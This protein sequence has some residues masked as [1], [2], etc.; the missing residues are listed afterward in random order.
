MLQNAKKFKAKIYFMCGDNEGDADVITDLNN[1]EYLVNT[2]RCE[3]KMLN[4]KVIVKGGQ[5]NEKLWRDGFVK[6][7]LWLN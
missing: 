1:V 3:C 2:K 6:A 4:K 5:H 7:Y